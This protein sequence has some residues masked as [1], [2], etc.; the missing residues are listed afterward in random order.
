MG[1][2]I[3]ALLWI[4]SQIAQL[5]ILIHCCILN[6]DVF[7]DLPGISVALLTSTCTRWPRD[8]IYLKSLPYILH[9][10]KLFGGTDTWSDRLEIPHLHPIFFSKRKCMMDGYSKELSIPHILCYTFIYRG[11]FFFTYIAKFSV[12]TKNKFWWYF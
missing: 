9:E 11:S 2:E 7:L 5:C 1:G 6:T 12:V 4:G 3:S 8:C 10:L